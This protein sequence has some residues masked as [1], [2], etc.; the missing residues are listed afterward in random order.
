MS[1][2]K[3]EKKQEHGTCLQGINNSTIYRIVLKMTRVDVLLEVA[4]V[5]IS[6]FM[7]F[8]CQRLLL[9][10][11]SHVG[12]MHLQ[13]ELALELLVKVC[14]PQQSRNNAKLLF[15]VQMPPGR[16]ALTTTIDTPMLDKGC[17]AIVRQ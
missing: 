5:G 1:C 17:K 8:C 3:I 11:Q 14:M 15:L 2:E 12:L 13:Q 4:H 10:T 9:R 7:R 6:T 16:S